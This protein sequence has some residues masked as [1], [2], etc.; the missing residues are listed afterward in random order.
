MQSSIRQFE[1]EGGRNLFFYEFFFLKKFERM[2]LFLK[3]IEKMELFLKKLEK[4]G[5]F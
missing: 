5:F 4:M 3:K 2:E 1:D